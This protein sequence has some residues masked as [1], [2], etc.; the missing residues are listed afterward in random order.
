MGAA[1]FAPVEDE[2]TRRGLLPEGPSGDGTEG[3]VDPADALVDT[4]EGQ[5]VQ[6]PPPPRP[7]WLPTWRLA[8]VLAALGV[9]HLVIVS[10]VR[11]TASGWLLLAADAVVVTFAIADS[12]TLPP[13]RLVWGRRLRPQ[14]LSLR[15]VETVAIRIE[16]ESRRRLRGAL[17]FALPDALVTPKDTVDVTVPKR[18]HTTVRFR[19]VGLRRG[20]HECLPLELRVPSAA[21]LLVRRYAITTRDVVPVYPNVKEA[22]RIDLALRRRRNDDAGLR[23]TRLLG[24]GTDFDSLRDY[25]P[26]DD[27]RLIDWHATARRGSP[28][29]RQYRI[30][31]NQNVLFLVDAG[32]L[33]AAP[34]TT[35]PLADIGPGDDPD[36]A[37]E[38]S[39]HLREDRLAFGR[40]TAPVRRLDVALNAATA[41]AY[42]CSSL[43]DRVGMV[44]FD[45]D[46]QVEIPPGRR[47]RDALLAAMCSLEPRRVESDYALAFR[48]AGGMRRALV[49]V[50]T[51]LLEDAAAGPILS[52]VPALARHHLVLVASVIDPDIEAAAT[53]G[54]RS[55]EAAYRQAVALDLVQRHEIAVR[56]LRALGVD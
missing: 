5:E 11:V 53:H 54:P 6:H 35:P 9:A 4:L 22:Q 56:R 10:V 48:V 20:R 40:V 7:R 32:R 41:M 26:D 1:T 8:V 52:A 3:D 37:D 17:R 15:V 23:H 49:V 28:V 39:A 2:F 30:E 34:I 21:R 47:S 50:F 16:N 27:F 38:V 43:D 44:A 42:V 13:S 14:L 18:G 45:S 36:I 25:R 46:M 33:M 51:D 31:R 55:G 12:A 29:S 19:V 24:I